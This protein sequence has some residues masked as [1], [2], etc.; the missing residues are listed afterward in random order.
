MAKSLEE[1]DLANT[2]AYELLKRQVRNVQLSQITYETTN[3]D[4]DYK[5]IFSNLSNLS[6][7]RLYLEFCE[8]AYS[9]FCTFTEGDWQCIAFLEHDLYYENGITAENNPY[10]KETSFAGG[11]YYNRT[12]KEIVFA[13]RGSERDFDDWVANDFYGFGADDIPG[14]FKNTYLLFVSIMS[15]LCNSNGSGLLDSQDNQISINDINK[16][17]FTGNSLGGGLAQLMS[18]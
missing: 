18:K 8:A 9:P 7:E 13:Y 1:Q 12:T 5:T 14:Q 10:D 15:K 17:T 16:I 2:L 3:S 11:V 6:A 4:S